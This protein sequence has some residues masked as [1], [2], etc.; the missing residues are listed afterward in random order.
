[1]SDEAQHNRQGRIIALVIAGTGLAWIAA[2]VAGE[3]L[4]WTQRMRAFF[5]LAALAG[6]GTAIWMI[7]GLWRSRQ[8]GRQEDKD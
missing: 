2:T 1:M 3:M 4:G 8:K 5:D 7:Y 6:F